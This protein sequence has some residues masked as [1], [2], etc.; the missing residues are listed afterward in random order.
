MRK[1]FLVA[2]LLAALA[3]VVI[4]LN[5]KANF[6]KAVYYSE[7]N[8]HEANERAIELFTR[9]I[10]EDPD[11]LLAYMGLAKCYL[12]NINYGWENTVASL[13]KAEEALHK[14]NNLSPGYPD[15]YHASIMTNLI[16][17]MRF[18]QDTKGKALSLAK[19]ALEKYPDHPKILAIAGYCYYLEFGKTG[20]EQAFKKGLELK[21]K[22][23]ELSRYQTEQII[24]IKMLILNKDFHGALD[25]CNT[26]MGRGIEN[27]RIIKT[28]QAEVF[29]YVGELEIS[30]MFFDELEI[31]PTINSFDMRIA[32]FATEHLGMIAVQQNKISH[33]EYLIEYLDKIGVDSLDGHVRRASILFGLGENERA[34]EYLDIFFKQSY[35]QKMKHI[36]RKNIALD[37]N[38][39]EEIIKKIDRRYYERKGKD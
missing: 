33:A 23:Y 14:V 19:E 39:S 7:K 29:Y 26:L 8:T 38:F 25:V 1:V 22:S 28:S 37:K 30:K 5:K 12:N 10:E 17:Y 31:P 32:E 24:F 21:K 6:T 2:I 35:A 27:P 36:Y 15:Y 13:A 34:F 3:V 16:R 18:D 9:A 4:S 20:N 11:R